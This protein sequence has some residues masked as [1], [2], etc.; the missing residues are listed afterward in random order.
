MVASGGKIPLRTAEGI[1][2]KLSWSGPAECARTHELRDERR[3]EDARGGRQHPGRLAH[4]ANVRGVLKHSA[5]AR[6]LVRKAKA[7]VRNGRFGNEKGGN[8]QDDLDG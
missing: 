4:H 2:R 5:P 3:D 8:K 1:R 7:E 6:R